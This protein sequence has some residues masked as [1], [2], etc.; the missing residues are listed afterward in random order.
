MKTF[1]FFIITFVLIFSSS[2]F[3]QNINKLE[4]Y[5]GLRYFFYQDKGSRIGAINVHVRAGSIFD[6]KGKYGTAF[7]LAGLLKKGGTQKYSTDALLNI[8]DKT[9]IELYTSCGKDFININ[10]KFIKSEEKNAFDILEQVLFHP[11]FNKKEFDN[12]KKETIGLITSYQNNNDYLALHQAAVALFK[13]S[14]YAHSSF[15][16]INS[17]KNLT[18][19]DEKEFYKKYFIPS[20]MI[21][22]FAGNFDKKNI[23]SFIKNNFKKPVKRKIKEVYP[24]Y[25]N[26]KAN[27]FKNKNLKQ[28][29]IYF[30][31]PSYG[32][33]TKEFYSLKIL[34]FILGGN[35]TSILAEK[36]RKE[37]GLAYSVYSFNY[38]YVNGGFFVIGMQTENFTRDKAISTTIEILKNLKKHGISEKKIQFAKNYFSGK[39]P[40]SLQSLL[41]IANYYSQGIFLNKS[42]PPWN[43]DLKYIEKVNKTQVDKLINKVFDFNKMI[44]SVVGKN[45]K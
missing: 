4:R 41:S 16:D 36:I 1:K 34:G 29:Y 3:A 7:I 27:L 26:K 17:V 18:I 10:L 43:D 19:K 23:S 25:S 31:F 15:G 32:L 28:S 42:L 35:L 21:I 37:L 45:G 24:I 2:I 33:K 5:N 30:L 8:L 11:S 6:K 12:I 40:I 22:T 38:P 14:E 13:N 9:G 44:I 39:I 20:N